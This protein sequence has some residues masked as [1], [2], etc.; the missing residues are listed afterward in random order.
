MALTPFFAQAV[1]ASFSSAIVLRVAMMQT[2][3]FTAF[4]TASASE[5]GDI[6]TPTGAPPMIS[7][8]SLPITA[9]FISKAAASSPPLSIT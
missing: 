6:F 8:T 2:S 5:A 1:K 9:G 4:N 3:G 7:Q